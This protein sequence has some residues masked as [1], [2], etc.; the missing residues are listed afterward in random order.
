MAVMAENPADKKR[1]L[2]FAVVGGGATGVETVAEL[3]EFVGKIKERYYKKN[4]KYK[5]PETS[6]Y[7]V[8]SGEEILKPFNPKIRGLA[9]GRLREIGVNIMLGLSVSSVEPETINLDGRKAISAGTIIWAAGVTPTTPKFLKPEPETV[10]GRLKVNEFLQMQ[11]KENV[12]ALGDNAWVESQSPLPEGMA[13]SAAGRPM[14]A[15]VAVVQAKVV[16]ENI[17]AEVNDLPMSPFVFKPKGSLISLGQWFAA[18]EIFGLTISGP[19]TWWIWR[20]VYLF[21]FASWEKRLKIASEW[22]LNL[23]LPRD[24]TKL[25]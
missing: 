1:L 13:T 7:L 18:G 3:S 4:K 25:S 9:E 23:F 2:S 15:Q 22:T 21:T 24:T 12:F 8:N 16:A 20:T 10:G 5:L 11:G 19:L 6:V 17:M 14:L